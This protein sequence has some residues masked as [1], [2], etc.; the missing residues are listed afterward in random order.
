[1][2]R[3]ALKAV[4]REIE[5]VFE[6]NLRARKPVRSDLCVDDVKVCYRANDVG[7]GALGEVE[8]A[9]DSAVPVSVGGV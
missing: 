1:M 7:R 2:A 6:T 8:P 3:T 9:M 5:Q 4:I